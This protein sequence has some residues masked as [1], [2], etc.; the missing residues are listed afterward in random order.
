MII[1]KE[2]TKNLRCQFKLV[3]EIDQYNV[4]NMKHKCNA[5][6]GWNLGKKWV[7]GK[8]KKKEWNMGFSQ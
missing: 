1:K 3:L 4:P 5:Y 2:D 8:N 6:P 7:L